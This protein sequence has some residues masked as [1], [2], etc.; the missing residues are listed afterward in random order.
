MRFWEKVQAVPRPPELA[1]SERLRVAA[2]IL[3]DDAGRVLIAER[4]GDAAFAGLWEFPGGKCREGEAP[5]DALRRELEEELGI[6]SRTAKPL[7]HLDHDYPD[8]R[9]SI[10]F[11]LV[12]QWSGRPRPLLGQRLRWCHHSE[13]DAAELLPADEPVLQALQD[14]TG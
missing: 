9:V 13:I 2:G 7:L 6:V 10:D 3:Y 11:F 5:A 1:N 14:I 8:R 4:K 12:E